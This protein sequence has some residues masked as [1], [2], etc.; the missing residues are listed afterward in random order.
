MK[1]EMV[2]RREWGSGLAGVGGMVMK[3]VMEC[4]SHERR[5]HLQRRRKPSR[6]TEDH[7][8]GRGQT[9]MREREFIYHH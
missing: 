4:M 5:S 8:E 2:L 1:V 7:W 6:G 3:T 9:V